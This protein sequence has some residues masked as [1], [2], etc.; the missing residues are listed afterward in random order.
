MNNL[1]LEAGLATVDK[2]NSLS[3]EQKDATKRILRAFAG[4]EQEEEKVYSAGNRFETHGGGIFILAR[5]NDGKAVLTSLSDGNQW[6]S[7]VEVGDRFAVTAS[8][9]TKMC[10][11]TGPSNFTRIEVKDD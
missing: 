5:A 6:A 3:P 1:N 11:V 9:F 7:P 2:A 10:G 4:V 8:E